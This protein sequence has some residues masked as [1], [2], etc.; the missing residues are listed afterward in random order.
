V[1]DVAVE[2]ETPLLWV[3]RDTLGL[4]GTEFGCGVAACG[5]CTRAR[6]RS[7]AAQLLAAGEI[8]TIEGLSPDRSQ[9]VQ[10][11]GSASRWRSA[12]TANPA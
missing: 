8:T 11:A 1:D 3:L 12:A 6:R 2:D 9:R 10:R 5:A 4:T 7:A